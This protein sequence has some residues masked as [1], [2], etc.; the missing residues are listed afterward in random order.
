MRQGSVVTLDYSACRCRP[1]L[2]STLDHRVLASRIFPRQLSQCSGAFGCRPGAHTSLY[3]QC[4]AGRRALKGLSKPHPCSHRE[5]GRRTGCVG[6]HVQ[7][8]FCDCYGS[9]DG[10]NSTLTVDKSQ[11]HAALDATGNNCVTK[12]R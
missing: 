12:S 2:L 4:T 8:F 7:K 5:A 11:A 10:N 1:R 3:V 6:P 9:V